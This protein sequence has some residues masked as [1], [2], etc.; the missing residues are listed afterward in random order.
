MRVGVS[1]AN[2][3]LRGAPKR[4]QPNWR[5]LGGKAKHETIRYVCYKDLQRKTTSALLNIDFYIVCICSTSLTYYY[6]CLHKFSYTS[7]HRIMI[8]P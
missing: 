3:Q 1:N 2:F 8:A 5:N 4:W 6:F 7:L